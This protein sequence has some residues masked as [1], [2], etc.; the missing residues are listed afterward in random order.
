MKVCKFCG[1]LAHWNSYF[2]DYI[3]ED[4]ARAE[5]EM[6]KSRSNYER[7]CSMSEQEMA[8]FLNT[9]LEVRECP[10]TFDHSFDCEGFDTC[11]KCWEAWLKAESLE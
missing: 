11:K 1:G 4:C 5:K 7:I 3:C 10:T 2:Q 8:D 6:R 9:I